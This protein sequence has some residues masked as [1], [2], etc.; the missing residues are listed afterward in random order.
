MSQPK[1]TSQKP[2]PP[3]G[4]GSAAP[5]NLSMCRYLPRST[6]S[7]SLT[8]TLTLLLPLLRT[9][10]SAGCS[11]VGVVIA[12]L[13]RRRGRRAPPSAQVRHAPGDAEVLHRCGNRGDRGLHV[14]GADRPDAAD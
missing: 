4:E 6:P 14:A 1:T 8:A 5:R 9:A 7:M 12:R 2:K 3:P 11:G 10:V 13:W